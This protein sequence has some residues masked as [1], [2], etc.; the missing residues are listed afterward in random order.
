MY[1]FD[2][3]MSQLKRESGFPFRLDKVFFCRGLILNS[4]RRNVVN[5]CFEVCLRLESKTA[6]C[7]DIINGK[8][9]RMPFPHA[10]WKLPNR[11]I[12]TRDPRGRNVLALIY[13]P[14]SVELFR[15][16]GMIPPQ[17][18]IPFTLTPQISGIVEKIIG[19]VNNIDSG[20]VPDKLDWLGFCLIKEVLMAGWQGTVELTMK[21]KMDNIALWL[22]VH[23]AENPE[24]HVLA[25]QNGMSYTRFYREW[26]KVFDETPLQFVIDA[27]LK[28]AAGLLKRTDIPISRIVKLVNFSGTYAFYR[29]FREKYGISPRQYREKV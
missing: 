19:L 28:T 10:V 27:R 14:E 9:I 8:A 25:E 5:D 2:L 12:R 16:A 20:G 15:R 13:P 3:D 1:Q 26:R 18:A 23:C 21:Q 24:F 22:T 6:V 29:R 17:G 7:E 11:Q 4:D